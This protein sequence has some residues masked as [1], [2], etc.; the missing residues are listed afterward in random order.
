[1]IA[2]ATKDITIFFSYAHE[3][4]PLR[5]ELEKQLSFLKRQGIISGWHDRDIQAG[6]E[7]EHEIDRHLNTAQIILLLISPDFMDSDYCY[8]VEMKRAMERREAREAHV[9]P[10]ILRPTLWIDAPF[11]KLQALPKNGKPVTSWGE[12]HDE[13]FLEIATGI[14]EI[15]RKLLVPSTPQPSQKTKEQYLHM[16]NIFFERKDYEEALAAYEQALR[17]DHNDTTAY[18]GKGKALHGLKRF[19]EALAAHKQAIRLDLN[20]ALAYTGKGDALSAMKDHYEALAAYEQAIRLALD[21]AP[22]YIGK[23]NALNDLKRYEEALAAFE[24]A[25]RLDPS[26]ASAYY[27]KGI[28]L[29]KLRRHDEALAAQEQAIRLDPSYVSYLSTK[30]T[31]A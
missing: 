10:I 1:M 9:I 18:N 23:G 17:L 31:N 13:A 16:G 5:K 26:F 29:R 24:Q 15:V 11:G 27:N 22:A 12:N 3:D 20:N 14:R 25:I 8:S 30:I 21:Y 28:I 19:E 2:E 7:W 4:E 6:Q